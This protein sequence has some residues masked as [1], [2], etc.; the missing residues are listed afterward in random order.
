MVDWWSKEGRAR[1][2]DA[3]ELLV[4]ADSG[5]SNGALCRAWKLAL[6]EKLADPFQLA[7][8]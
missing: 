3:P 8:T 6:Q 1:Y 2:Q 7:V 4:L 5:G